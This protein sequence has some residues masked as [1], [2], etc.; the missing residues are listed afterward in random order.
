MSLRPVSRSG[1][2]RLRPKFL[3]LS[4]FAL[5]STVA[6]LVLL[7]LLAVGLL[8]LSGITLR[9]STGI[10]AQAEA[11][12]NA[13]LALNLALGALQSELGPDRRI[14]GHASLLDSDPETEEPDD[15][16]H[17][18]WTGVWD[19]WATGNDMFGDDRPSDHR[20]VLLSSNTR[21]NSKPGMNPSYRNHREDHFRRWLV[22]IDAEQASSLETVRSLSQDGST[23]PDASATAVTLVGIGSV[24]DKE[25]NQV[26]APLQRCDPDAGNTKRRSGR[27]AWWVADESTK[28]RIMADAWEKEDRELARSELMARSQSSG[29]PGHEIIEELETLENPNVIERSVSRRTLELATKE[30]AAPEAIRGLHHDITPWSRG[31]LTDVREGGMKKDLSALLERPIST[32]RPIHRNRQDDLLYAF[33]T[34]GEE[35]VPIQD[36]A[37]YYQCYR[38]VVKFTNRQSGNPLA[39]RSLQVNNIDF[40]SRSNNPDLGNRFDF[41][42]EYSN[43]YRMPIPIKVQFMLSYIAVPRT[44]QDRREQPQNRDTHKLH[45][46]LT[47]S[48]TFWNPYNVPLVM[49]AGTPKSTQLRLFN[50]PFG[51]TW[52]KRRWQ[53]PTPNDMV[54]VANRNQ[55]SGDRD[56]GFTLYV[57]GQRPVVFQPGEVRIFSLREGQLASED[58]LR[59]SN[60]WRSYL[61]SHPGW[62]PRAYL[63]LPRSERSNDRN[64]VQIEHPNG[65]GRRADGGALTFRAG[66]RISLRLDANGS[67]Q[68]ANG[69]ALHFFI[70]QSNTMEGGMDQ[71]IDWSHMRRQYQLT[72]RLHTENQTRDGSNQFNRELM[73]SIFPDGRESITLDVPVN[74][75]IRG[76][77]QA[78]MVVN[79]AASCEISEANAGAYRGRRA[80]ARPFLHSTPI[81]SVSFIDRADKDAAYHHGWNWWIEPVNSEDEVGAVSQNGRNSFFGGGYTADFGSSFVIQQEVPVT[82]PQSIAAL[83]HATLS[84]YSLADRILGSNA[85]TRT[86]RDVGSY[87]DNPFANTTATGGN[88]LFPRTSQAVGNSYAHPHIPA[89]RAYTLW[90]RHFNVTDGPRNVNLVDHSYLAN[91]ALWDDYFFSSITSRDANDLRRRPSKQRDRIPSKAWDDLPRDRSITAKAL[92]RRFFFEDAVLPNPRFSPVGDSIDEDELDR[93]FTGEQIGTAGADAMAAHLFVEG[94]FNVNSTSP[95]AWKALF[96]GARD[97]AVLVHQRSNGDQV[98]EWPRSHRSVETEGTPV[99][100]FSMMTGEPWEGSSGDPADPDQWHA[101]RSLTDEQLDEL[102]L[103]MVEQVKKRGPFLSL[104]EFVNRRLDRSDSELSKKG[105]LQSALDDESVSINEGFRNPDRSFGSRELASLSEVSFPEALEGPIAYGSAAYVDQADLLRHL[106]GQLSPRGDCFV[107]RTYGDSLASDG[108][109]LARAWCEAVVQ[110]YPQYI[111]TE[112]GEDSHLAYDQLTSPANQRFGRAFRIISFRWLNPDEV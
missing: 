78:F 77:P 85:S 35:Q 90:Q 4:G 57:G 76:E 70:R 87:R 86:S 54:W 99:S 100:G 24:G 23:H 14:S 7:T 109:V 45:I 56:T 13:R 25:S 61:E 27:Y 50:I 80:V 110:R 75:I 92:A 40:G 36:L 96:A 98:G 82:P 30:D 32:R 10:S 15:L 101:W 38:D 68:M 55:E 105:A 111:D 95:K 6:L 103:A 43:I 52:N 17:P 97:H 37:A 12:A 69:A 47:P 33:G 108:S 107:I 39:P 79:M 16:L 31:L 73:K 20:T 106:G 74:T 5:V 89:D 41:T 53:S 2:S 102:S 63:E 42:R 66:D 3:P 58:E 11:R 8:S 29:S 81:K 46:G 1:S 83:S 67:R 65:T 59:N 48:L 93:L 28:A 44:S 71:G 104:S 88:G 18:H 26:T 91:K 21:N 84:G 22:S 51:L 62:D 72:S 94:P 64:H 34:E 9:S 112:A 60:V 19:S 49:N